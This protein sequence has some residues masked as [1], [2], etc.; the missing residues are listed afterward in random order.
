MILT[1]AL[2]TLISK[3]GAYRAVFAAWNRT[4]IRSATSVGSGAG[5]ARPPQ[6]TDKNSRPPLQDHGGCPIIQ[7][8]H[9]LASHVKSTFD[10]HWSLN[11]DDRLP[12]AKR[13]AA[14]RFLAP[15]LKLAETATQVRCLD[16][17]CGDGVHLSVLEAEAGPTTVCTGL[18]ISRAA[19]GKALAVG[20]GNWRL[21]QGDV[22][23]LPF[24]DNSFDLT[25]SFGVLAYTG[26]PWQGLAE[27]CRV[28]RPGGLVGV[29]FSPKPSG[30]TRRVLS[31]VR[32]LARVI[33]PFWR[34]RLADLIVPFLPILPTVSGIS[35]F[36]AS[37]RQCR[38][39]VLV[40]IAPPTLMYP[41]QDEVEV[42]ITRCSV[43]L[44]WR[45]PEMPI[46]IWARK[47]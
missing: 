5:S 28:T 23:M 4:N 41:T 6:V 40:N 16:A 36:N 38:E 35:L 32:T 46:T 11:N 21:I 8:V 1:N 17:G 34:S 18:D 47:T 13:Q 7:R 27:L 19:L 26:Q 24:A 25:I 43:Q 20:Q 29:W 42:E 10:F 9:S 37:W 45:D 31:V 2:R 3:A 14:L 44:E 15:A 22:G 12:A 33:G 30:G 39:V